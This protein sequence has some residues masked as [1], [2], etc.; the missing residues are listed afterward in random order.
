MSVPTLPGITAQT[1]TSSRITTRVLF[2]GDENGIPVVFIHGNHSSATYWE[3]TMLALPAGYR[4]IAPDNRG[5]G[6]ADRSAKI[7]ATRGLRDLSDDLATLLDTLKIEKAHVVGHSLGGSVLWA[8]MQDY[9]ERILT[10]TQVAPGSPFGFGGTKGETGEPSFPD[11]AGSGLVSHDFAALIAAGD[12]SSDNQ[13]SPRNVMN[14]FY[15][16]PPFV[17]A[18]LEDLLSST[19][20]I[21]S[22]APDYPG[23]VVPSENFPGLSAGVK[24]PNNAISAKYQGDVSKLYRITPKPPVLW[25]RGA[26]DQ[27]VGDASMFD[28]GTLGSLGA[29]PGYPGVEVYPPQPM[30]KQTRYV[31]EQYKQNGGDY[32]EVVLPDTAHTP[33]IEKPEDFNRAFHV[34]LSRVAVGG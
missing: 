9:P 17:P 25:I 32:Q 13:L 29:I 16:K 5:Y 15:W 19:L 31:L 23:D 22:E 30:V 12:R 2:S 10:V 21:H 28:L 14:A 8:F 4:G 33:Y 18:R 24:G 3:E 34:H 20:S 1:I 6:D 7:D 26:D 11:F 27:I